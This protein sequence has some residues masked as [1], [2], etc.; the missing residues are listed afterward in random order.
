MSAFSEIR[1]AEKEYEAMS[2]HLSHSQK[3]EM[4]ESI[5][6]GKRWLVVGYGSAA[7]MALALLALWLS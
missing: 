6:S 7:L 5:A 1:D 3:E 2:P 4:R